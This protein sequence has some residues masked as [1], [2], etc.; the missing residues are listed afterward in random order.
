MGEL[1]EWESDTRNFGF[2]FYSAGSCGN[3]HV[4]MRRHVLWEGTHQLLCMFLT[5]KRK[6]LP[7]CDLDGVRNSNRPETLNNPAL[8]TS[9]GTFFGLFLLLCCFLCFLLLFFR[10]DKMQSERHP[11]FTYF[12]VIAFVCLL[13]SATASAQIVVTLTD[14]SHR[15]YTCG[16]HSIPCAL[17]FGFGLLQIQGAASTAHSKENKINLIKI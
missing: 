13:S 6:T 15:R 17:R 2:S 9:S 7:L 3:S 14:D 16:H 11:S 12:S 10:S 5:V 8:I 1:R 4:C